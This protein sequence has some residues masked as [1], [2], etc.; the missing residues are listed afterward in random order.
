MDI[1]DGRVAKGVGFKNL[2][3]VG[4]PVELAQYYSD[5]G[6]DELV[7]L[8]V[9]ATTERRDTLY[10]LV[11]EVARQ[12]T[13]PFTVG[14]GIRNLE[15]IRTLLNIG[16]DK[17]SIGS[18]A[19]TDSRLIRAAAEE[20]GSQCIVVSLDPKNINNRWELYTAGGRHATGVEAVSFAKQLQTLGAGELLVNSLD[21]DGTKAGYDIPLLRAIT[22]TVS[23]PVI[24]SSGAGT[25]AHFLEAFQ[26]AGVDAVLAASLFHFGQ[27]SITEL[28]TYL[29]RNG[30][31]VGQ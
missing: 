4:D 21:R 12:I 26:E 9:M 29:Q 24:A 28:K 25:K 8:D 14:G 1:K 2:S 15:D 18:A 17:V 11:E 10:H 5:S 3:D 30:V 27:M 16:A 23:I 19:I 7:F 13:I 31:T 20:F 6:A 22:E